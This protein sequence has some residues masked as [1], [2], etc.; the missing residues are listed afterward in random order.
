MD[1]NLLSSFSSSAEPVGVHRRL[2][3]W[4]LSLWYVGVL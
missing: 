3:G 2:G 1:T 4:R